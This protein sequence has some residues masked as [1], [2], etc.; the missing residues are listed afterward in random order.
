MDARAQRILH[1]ALTFACKLRPDSDQ[2]KDSAC[3]A[4]KKIF[5]R[6]R[7]V[8]GRGADRRCCLQSGSK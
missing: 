1:G 6:A 7:E 3:T 5:L 2:I 8:T 4:Q